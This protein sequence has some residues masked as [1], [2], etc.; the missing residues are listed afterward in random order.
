[1]AIKNKRGRARTKTRVTSS[2]RDEREDPCRAT[3][4]VKDSEAT[5]GPVAI[6]QKKVPFWRRKPVVWTATAVALG[7]F[8]AIGQQIATAGS[9]AILDIARKSVRT[10]NG[11]EHGVGPLGVDIYALYG[12]VDE[13]ALPKPLVSGFGHNW[14]T[15]TDLSSDPYGRMWVPFLATN[16]GGPV[17]KLQLDLV[18]TGQAPGGVRVTNIRVRLVKPPEPKFT[19]TVIYQPIFAVGE[20]GYTFS[21]N[22][23]SPAP[24][25]AGVGRQQAFPAFNLKLSKGEQSTVSIGFSAKHFSYA[26]DLDIDYLQRTHKGTLQV[27]WWKGKPFIL[28]GRAANY[29]VIYDS[30]FPMG[31]GWSMKKTSAR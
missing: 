13:F 21:V 10:I 5:V 19:G 4:N 31:P 27:A 22:L 8:G 20:P 3:V 12:K 14:L 18:L 17:R 9:G 6:N 11:S 26:W 24:V 29:H 28:T 15:H 1:L 7:A 23:D 2:R 30:N 16:N 25:L